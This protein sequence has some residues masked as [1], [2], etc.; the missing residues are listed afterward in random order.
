MRERVLPH[1]ARDIRH[2]DIM[3]K[4]TF[5]GPT[6]KVAPALIRNEAST[7]PAVVHSS[8]AYVPR[9]SAAQ[10]AGIRSMLPQFVPPKPESF[11]HE[12]EE[13]KNQKRAANRKSAY[14]SRARKKKMVEEMTVA[15]QDLKQHAHI[16]DLLPDLIIV[17]DH[18]E[19]ISFVSKSV[20]AKLYYTDE[21]LD[22]V[23]IYNLMTPET[24]HVITTALHRKGF[25]CTSGKRSSKSG[26]S[27]ASSKSSTVTDVSFVGADTRAG[28]QKTPK[29]TAGRAYAN[30]PALASKLTYQN[31]Q[32]RRRIISVVSSVSSESSSSNLDP[33]E[34][35]PRRCLVGPNTQ[36]TAVASSEAASLKKSA[37]PNFLSSGGRQGSTSSRATT[38]SWS[39]NWNSSD[40]DTE[41]QGPCSGGEAEDQ[42]GSDGGPMYAKWSHVN[43]QRHNQ[44]IDQLSDQAVWKVCLIRRDRTSVWCEMSVNVREE[45]GTAPEVVLSLRPVH[46]GPPVPENYVLTADLKPNTQG[47]PQSGR[48]KEFLG[49]TTTQDESLPESGVEVASALSA[50]NT[51]LGL[52]GKSSWPCGEV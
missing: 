24:R 32:K 50:A 12:E 41:S 48:D 44:E 34:E 46:D 4:K 18:H 2:D 51:L 11:N 39:S 47:L 31:N 5:S 9:D 45:A 16:L 27:V 33:L 28:V 7:P 38:L 23:S 25:G 49:R 8:E 35:I 26:R 52:M 29:V 42:A 13:K 19:R 40:G 20:H 36:I 6:E 30:E 43:L 1:G 22:G 3:L 10:S 15:N 14:T 21:D 17:V 37:P